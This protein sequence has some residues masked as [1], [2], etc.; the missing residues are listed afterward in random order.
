MAAY[1]QP[2]HAH[3]GEF[4]SYTFQVDQPAAWAGWSAR[5]QVRY[6]RGA[7]LLLVELDTDIST[8]GQVTVTMPTDAT[9]ALEP[10]VGEWDLYVK[11]ASSDPQY[12]VEG[13]VIITGRVTV[14]A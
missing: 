14:P 10:F 2:L 7:A 8:A 6:W 1:Q 5:A 3:V 11:A 13:P 4:W 9:S 12:I